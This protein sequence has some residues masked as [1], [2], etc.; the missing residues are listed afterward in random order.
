VPPKKKETTA[1]KKPTPAQMRS[2]PD[3]IDETIEI[4]ADYEDS[5]ESW[6]RAYRRAFGKGC[7]EKGAIL[8]A[9][10]HFHEEMFGGEGEE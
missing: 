3:L 7:M 10:A 1:Q 2:N 5:P 4:P 8:Y 6:K 9:D